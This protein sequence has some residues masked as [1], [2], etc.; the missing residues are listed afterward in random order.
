MQVKE[1]TPT[2]TLII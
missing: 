2:E 1:K